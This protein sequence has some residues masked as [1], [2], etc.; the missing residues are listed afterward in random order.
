MGDAGDSERA[1]MPDLSVI[2]AFVRRNAVWIAATALVV[3][4]LCVIAVRLAFDQYSAT[5][6]VL[7][8][9]RNA[10]VTQTQEVLPDIGPDSIAIESLVQVAKS[11]GFL[12]ALVEKEEL[13]SD[14]EF[15]GSAA[16]SADKK[17]RGAR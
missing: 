9:P 16:S 13:S 17:R 8:D 6:T 4:L 10:N 11:D 14:P 2:L 15:T 12:T 1:K 3:S 7:F 5:A